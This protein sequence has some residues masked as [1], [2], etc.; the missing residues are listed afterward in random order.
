MGIG[1]NNNWDAISILKRKLG[2]GK[3]KCG[4]CDRKGTSFQILDGDR[5]HFLGKI[6]KQWGDRRPGKGGGGDER[7][8]VAKSWARPI[9][10]GARTSSAEIKLLKSLRRIGWGKV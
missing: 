10:T 6:V 8:I 7:D 9:A 4:V 1:N 3:T 5:L 2:S